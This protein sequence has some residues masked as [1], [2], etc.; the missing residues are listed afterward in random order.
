MWL[1]GIHSKSRSQHLIRRSKIGLPLSNPFQLHKGNKH[2]LTLLGW[3]Y[4]CFWTTAGFWNWES[5]SITYMITYSADIASLCCCA[6]RQ[7]TECQKLDFKTVFPVICILDRGGEELNIIR[8][9]QRD[10]VHLFRCH[11]WNTARSRRIWRNSARL[12]WPTLPLLWSS[13]LVW[14]FLVV[15]NN[16]PVVVRTSF[17]SSQDFDSSTYNI[18]GLYFVEQ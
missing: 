1:R 10:H 16:N 2:G 3:Y 12:P 13:L 9:R 7:G 14:P 11:I 15:I 18:S 6:E 8:A 5:C 17:F 4:S